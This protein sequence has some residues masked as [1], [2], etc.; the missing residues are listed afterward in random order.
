MMPVI[1]EI[2]AKR[3]LIRELVLKD[4]KLRYSRPTLG[5]LWAFLSPLLLVAIFYLVFSLFLRVEVK[6]AP[7]PIYLMSAIFSWRFFQDSLT[8]SATSLVDNK[9]LIKEAKFPHYLIPLSVVLANCVIYLPSLGILIIS[10]LCYLKG[11]P[12]LIILLPVVLVIHLLITIG[13]S[14]VFSIL[15]VKWRDVR[16]VL[17]AGL[18]VLFYLTPAFYSL[19][20]VKGSFTRLLFKAYIYNP[21]TAMLNL[22]RVTLVKGFYNFIQEDIGLAV[23]IVIPVVFAFLILWLGSY[24]YNKNKNSINDYLSY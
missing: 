21:F 22:Y 12:L 3:S 19:Q 23:L 14:L 2:I 11:L 10:A 13:S 5:F 9:N 18:T 20:L 6:E 16:Y 17:E 4:L 24:L 7:F 8:C 15:Y 1:E